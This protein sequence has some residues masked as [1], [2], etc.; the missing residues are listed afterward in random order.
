MSMRDGGVTSPRG[1]PDHEAE[2]QAEL[3]RVMEENAGLTA[4]VSIK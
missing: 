4:E 3:A 2:L 1:T